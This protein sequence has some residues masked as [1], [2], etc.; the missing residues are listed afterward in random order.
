MILPTAHGGDL[1]FEVE[2]ALADTRVDVRDGQNRCGARRRPGTRRYAPIERW[3]QR[4]AA[5]GGDRLERLRAA[6]RAEE[7]TRR[8]PPYDRAAENDRFPP[9]GRRPK[10]S[11]MP[12]RGAASLYARRHEALCRRGEHAL[13]GGR[14]LHLRVEGDDAGAGRDGR[15]RVAG[16]RSSLPASAGNVPTPPGNGSPSDATTSTAPFSSR[17]IASAAAFPTV[18]ATNATSCRWP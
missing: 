8:A 15:D 13:A 16:P 3:R 2:Q 14:M 7:A 11:N 4:V 17:R 1:A 12:P 6:R 10:P 9:H 18:A 5:A